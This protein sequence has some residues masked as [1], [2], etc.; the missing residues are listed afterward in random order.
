MASIASSRLYPLTESGDLRYAFVRVSPPEGAP[1]FET[2]Q[3]IDG[4]G[5][6]DSSWMIE[7]LDN[8]LVNP[9]RKVLRLYPKQHA[10]AVTEAVASVRA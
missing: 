5:E 7:V 9:P 8:G 2:G 4:P 1:E 3:T 6:T 10:A